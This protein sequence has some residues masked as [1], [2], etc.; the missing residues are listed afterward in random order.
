MSAAVTLSKSSDDDYDGPLCDNSQDKK[1][2]KKRKMESGIPKLDVIES[3]M[4][5]LV[6]K[7]ESMQRKFFESMEKIELD[8]QAKEELWRRQEVARWTREHELRV[9][10]HALAATRDAALIGFLQKVT[11]QT[12]QLTKF[13]TPSAPRDNS[14]E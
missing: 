4:K 2:K 9:Q 12:V 3:M 10:E 13:S 1:S 14:E 7:Q 8:R 11:G 5:T 6:E